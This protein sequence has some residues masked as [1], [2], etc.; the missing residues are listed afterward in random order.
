MAE[1][2]VPQCAVHE[3]AAEMMHAADDGELPWARR[4]NE[5][6]AATRSEGSFLPQQFQKEV[7]KW[8]KSYK[9]V[10]HTVVHD[11]Q[12]WCFGYYCV[13]LYFGLGSIQVEEVH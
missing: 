2:Q 1:R 7:H 11:C 12:T 5:S 8:K 3:G 9:A 13:P 10:V 4:E 6:M